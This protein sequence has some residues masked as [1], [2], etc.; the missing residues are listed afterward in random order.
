MYVQTIYM[1]VMGLGI[2]LIPQVQLP[3]F[4]F[5]P[6]QEIW[7][8]VLGALILGFGYVNLRMTQQG[9]VPY[10]EASIIGRSIFCSI[11]CIFGL[12]KLV[13]PSIFLLAAG[14]MTFTIWAYLGLKKIKN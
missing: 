9:I 12:M 4:G 1:F 11:I 14:E 2:V 3:L 5:Q 7:V 8:R 13:E 6:P 10:I